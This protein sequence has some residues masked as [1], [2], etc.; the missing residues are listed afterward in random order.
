MIRKSWQNSI[1]FADQFLMH[2]KSLTNPDEE[3]YRMK[4]CNFLAQKNYQLQAYNEVK[5]HNNT[6]KGPLKFIRFR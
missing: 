3:K 6:K 5:V 2:I 1:L 4:L